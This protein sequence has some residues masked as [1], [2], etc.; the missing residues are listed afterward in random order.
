MS[1]L[2]TVTFYVSLLLIGHAGFSSFEFHQLAKKINISDPQLPRDI[3]Y[4]SYLGLILFII[5]AFLAFTK[6][7]YLPLRYDNQ[8]TK[9]VLSQGQYL[10][11]TPFNKATNVDNM[12]GNDANGEVNF[13]T[14]FIDISA[15]RAQFKKSLS[16]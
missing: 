6:L 13:M 14:S 11:E 9:Q 4:E 2:S 7:T 5:S 12:I 1:L 8:S 3:K 16:N 10:K 15:K